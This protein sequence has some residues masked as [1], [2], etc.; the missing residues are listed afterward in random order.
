VHEYFQKNIFNKHPLSYTILGSNES[1]K[2]IDQNILRDY[3]KKKYVAKNLIISAAGNV[4]HKKLEDYIKR[5]FQLS[6]GEK[7]SRSNGHIT[8]I[9]KEKKYPR[10]VAQSHICIGNKSI[11][12]SDPQKYTLLILH[13]LLGGG[14]SSRLFQIVR[15]KY[16][17]AYTIFT[18]AD[19]YS[20][21]GIFGVYL[22]VD[23]SNIKRSIKLIRKEFE[24]VK[25]EEISDNELIRLK[26]QIKGNLM[27]GLESTYSRMN[28][29]AKMEMY[30]KRYFTLDMVLSGIEEV[31]S[32]EVITLANTLLNEDL[33]TSIILPK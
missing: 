22:G 2:S 14:M 26:S 15:E 20:D 28:R 29:L 30:L 9:N 19:F 33:S 13:A 24:K 8:T 12:Y 3:C 7:I 11:P 23:K 18:F 31:K 4:D 16:S 32:S 17:V 27:L 10:N 25:K 6:S 21:T 5:Y 1:I